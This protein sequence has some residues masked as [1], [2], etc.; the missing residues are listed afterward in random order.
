MSQMTFDHHRRLHRFAALLQCAMTVPEVSKAV[1]DGIGE[2]IPADKSALYRL[3]ADSGQV[4]DVYSEADDWFLDEYEEYCRVD[5]PLLDYVVRRGRPI[6]ST[7]VTTRSRWE[8]SGNHVLLNR[9]GLSFS[10]EAPVTASGTLLGTMKFARSAT[11]GA[12]GEAELAIATLICEQLGLA[13]ERAARFDL[14]GQRTCMLE[15]VLD[16]LPEAVVVTDLEAQVLFL[17]RAARNDPSLAG[18]DS[19]PSPDGCPTIREAIVE[20]MEDFRLNGKR[21]HIRLLRDAKGDHWVV[22]SC[23]LGESHGAAMTMVFDGGPAAVG[24]T[25]PAWHVLT[26]REQEIAQLVAEGLTAKEIAKRAYITENTVK[27]H[28]KRV[29]AKTDAR[30]RAEL[31]QLIWTSGHAR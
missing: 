29:F 11:A 14:T 13:M 7:R 31:V 16:R 30:N 21:V 15:K 20:A 4:L 18:P 12:F 23:R 9:A 19:S 3:D 25:L 2:V 8:L 17:N 1:V 26:K 27:Q 22:K 6:D 10:L 24:G 5:D 28:L